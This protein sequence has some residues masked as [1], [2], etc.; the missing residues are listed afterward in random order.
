MEGPLVSQASARQRLRKPT[1]VATA[2]CEEGEGVRRGGGAWC[3][4]GEGGGVWAGWRARA[5]GGGVAVRSA[6][7]VTV[8]LTGEQ[9]RQGLAKVGRGARGA[10]GAGGHG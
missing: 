6:A 9:G 3:A 5:R 2:T 4:R 8:R 10:R 1:S 7:S